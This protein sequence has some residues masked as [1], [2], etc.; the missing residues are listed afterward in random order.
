VKLH[1]GAVVKLCGVPV[2]GVAPTVAVPPAEAG[3]VN[4]P[5]SR[6]NQNVCGVVTWTPG[7][8]SG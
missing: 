5:E 2:S 8:V 1:V 7:D 3:A 4:L 6:L